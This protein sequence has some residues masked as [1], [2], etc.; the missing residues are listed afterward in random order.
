MV[1]THAD[2]SVHHET[3]DINFRGVLAFGLGLIVAAVLIHLAVWLLFL[4]FSARVTTPSGL[5][6]PLS[7]GQENR[8]PPQP[9]LQTNPRKDLS[10]MRAT[11]D[12]L[13]TTYGWV[14][15]NAGT[16]RI[17][18]DQAMKLTLQRGLPARAQGNK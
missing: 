13:L 14:D 11:E 2:E 5:Q 15:K 16:V 7:K 3:S 18:I 9:R 10:D 6:Y 1:M 17:P 8:L 4:Y 12:Q